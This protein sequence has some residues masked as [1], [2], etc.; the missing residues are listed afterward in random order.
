MS[1]TSWQWFSQIQFSSPGFCSSL[2]SF[3][4]SVLSSI[5]SSGAFPVVEEESDR[6]GNHCQPQQWN[7]IRH[8]SQYI[9]YAHPSVERGD[10]GMEWRG[11][12]FCPQRQ[13]TLEGLYLVKPLLAT[14][15]NPA[16]VQIVFVYF[17]T[18]SL[19]LIELTW[20]NGT[21]GIVPQ[22]QTPS[23]W[24]SR[25]TLIKPS[26]YLKGNKCSLNPGLPL[27]SSTW[28]AGQSWERAVFHPAIAAP[29]STCYNTWWIDDIKTTLCCSW[30][31]EV[32]EKEYNVCSNMVFKWDFNIIGTGW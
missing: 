17:Q 21:N 28:N 22:M 1:R 24:Q 12:G 8:S 6:F 10:G 9:E 13:D 27:R 30:Q 4:L 11:I 31:I 20:G 14:P 15:D 29:L 25:Q 3:I 23:I 32:V 26:N 18:H 5:Q 19:C 7:H 16:C 2:D